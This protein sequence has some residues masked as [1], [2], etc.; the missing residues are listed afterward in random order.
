VVE[1]LRPVVAQLEAAYLNDELGRF[2]TS[3]CE[4]EHPA[5]IEFPVGAIGYPGDDAASPHQF[6]VS[7][8]VP[9]SGRTGEFKAR[10]WLQGG[11]WN[12]H[13]EN[14]ELSDS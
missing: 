9:E 8:Q 12:A 2:L 7:V 1:N 13:D 4:P 6:R 11:G 10:L 14:L 5:A 3:R